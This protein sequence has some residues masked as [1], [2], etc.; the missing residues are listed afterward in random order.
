MNRIS[1]AAHRLKKLLKAKVALFAALSVCACEAAQAAPGDA[2]PSLPP[3][4][5]AQLQKQAE[6]LRVFYVEYVEARDNPAVAATN[7]NSRVER[8]FSVYHEDNRFYTRW[9]REPETSVHDISFDGSVFY[10]ANVLD[11]KKMPPAMVKKAR[12]ADASDPD[13]WKYQA[14]DPYLD[15][16]GFFSPERVMEM[17]AF[18]SPEP[19]LLHYSNQTRVISVDNGVDKIRVTART[20]DRWV[21]AVRA[22]DIDGYKKELERRGTPAAR[23]AQIVANYERLKKMP[24]ERNVVWV[25]EPRYEG[26]ATS[27]EEYNLDSKLIRRV[28]TDDWKFYERPGVWLPGKITIS[29]YTM[30]TE[31]YTFSDTPI[32]ITAMELKVAEFDRRQVEYALDQKKEYQVAG[33]VVTDRSVPEARSTQLHQVSYTVAANGTLLQTSASNVMPRTHPPYLWI[34]LALAFAVFPAMLLGK[35]LKG[36]RKGR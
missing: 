26:A 29:D 10:F 5:R 17:E 11:P 8:Q 13:R 33:T 4:L 12:V 35:Y 32:L 18:T 16:L 28:E 20:P 1:A 14:E 36:S 31:L 22:M 30:P 15:G 6:A 23:L 19:L 21:E 9:Q 3:E 27:R 7:G 2:G 25:F 24:A 34:I